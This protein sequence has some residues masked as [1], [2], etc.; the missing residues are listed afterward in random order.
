MSRKIGISITLDKKFVDLIHKGRGNRSRYVNYIFSIG[1][2]TLEKE[3]KMLKRHAGIVADTVIFLEAAHGDI[4]WI[5]FVDEIL[6]E[7]SKLS[8]SLT[9]DD[10]LEVDFF[11][12][13]T[14]Q[15]KVFNA[16][17]LEEFLKFFQKTLWD[18]TY[19]DLTD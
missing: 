5:D 16:D 18:D 17:E 3:F 2:E 6:I 8:Y 13:G 19:N 15:T 11:K 14:P 10:E 4:D 7:N 1:F 9:E 12:D